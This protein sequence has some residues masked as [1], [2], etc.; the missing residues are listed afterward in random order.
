MHSHLVT[1]AAIVICWFAA[2]SPARAAD[3]RIINIR[4]KDIIYDPFTQKIYASVPSSA[5]ANGNSITT[6]DP[7]TGLV[8]NSVFI[9]SE[10]GKLALSD[11]G[12][13]LYVALDGAAAVRRFNMST[14][15]A[16]LQFTL[17]ND[18]FLG[19]YFAEDMA[20]QPGNPGVLAVS[21]RNLGFSPRHEGVAIYDNGVQRSAETPGHTGSNVIEFSGS[22]SRLYGYNNETTDFGFRRMSVD[23]NGVTIID[24]TS[25]IIS[26]FFV[27]IKF[28]GG[29]IFSTSGR[30]V[31]PEA[32]TLLGTFSFPDHNFPSAVLP[33]VNTGRVYFVAG[34]KLLTYDW[35]TLTL[36]NNETIP[37]MVGSA[38]SLIRWGQ[39]GLAFR[40]TGD[41][42]ILLRP[43]G[44]A[45]S[46]DLAVVMLGPA[47][48]GGG[49][50]II[51]DIIVTNNGSLK[52]TDVTLTELL[53][54]GDIPAGSTASVIVIV[55]PSSPGSIAS[56]V[57]V[58][59]NE[60]DANTT[61]N[62][63]SLETNGSHD[64]TAPD[65]AGTWVSM[66]QTCTR[67]ARPTCTLKGEF[68]VT[69]RGS[70]TAPQSLLRFFASLD[71]SLAITDS[72]FAQSLV[73]QLIPNQSQRVSF[74][75][76]LPRGASATGLHI[77]GFLD[78]LGSIVETDEGNNSIAFGPIQ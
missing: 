4:T 15:T 48:T 44:N 28:E 71:G 72:V 46:S 43:N 17:G 23:D 1:I 73:G 19:L 45:P 69:N 18:S 40:T 59:A 67:R 62:L 55:T 13:F 12:Q 61:D 41:Q 49:K 50:P 66:V 47:N 24:N 57:A 42:V 2:L 70:T 58:N 32:R 65:L 37:G 29:L 3:V 31:D 6:I 52:A 78:A 51:Y 39:D 22:P 60:P 34:N 38:S 56:S 10:P 36:L 33:N 20:V 53:N 35:E 11:D 63:A 77:I 25:N 74:S 27:D 54:L 76:K 8:G 7:A 21:R 14:Q 68:D 26:G 9:G 16:G 5:G 64:F 75:V 30:V